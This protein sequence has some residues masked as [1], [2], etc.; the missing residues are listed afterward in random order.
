LYDDSRIV[1]IS[2][3]EILQQWFKCSISVIYYDTKKV[4]FLEFQDIQEYIIL[5]L[6]TYN[7]ANYIEEED[8]I[9]VTLQLRLFELVIPSLILTLSHTPPG[10]VWL[11]EL[12]QPLRSYFGLYR[13]FTITKAAEDAL[14]WDNQTY[15]FFL[16]TL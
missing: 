5:W 12:C 8:Q 15:Q 2:I 4:T 14:I 7:T 16:R 6:I 9:Y 13:Q 10:Y 1:P 3:S 11:S